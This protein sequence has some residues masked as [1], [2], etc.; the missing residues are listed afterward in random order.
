MVVILKI[1]NKSD[2]EENNNDSKFGIVFE[3]PKS[4]F[5]IQKTRLKK[6]VVVW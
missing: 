1:E 6:K 5:N 4:A 2:K 3:R